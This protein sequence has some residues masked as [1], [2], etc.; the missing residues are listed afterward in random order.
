MKE[1]DVVVIGA[2]PAGLAAANKAAA[3][4]A[5]VLAIDSN[6]SP[7][8]QLV[9][10]I[11]KFFGSADICAGTRGIHLADKFYDEAKKNGC[12][13]MLGA[14]V[15]AIERDGKG[16]MIYTGDGRKTWRIR[17]KTTVLALG[18]SENAI[19][20]DGW[21]K[22][23][24]ITA[25]AAQTLVNQY[26][27]LC[28]KKVLMVGSGNVGLIVS[29]QLTQ[30][31]IDIAAIVEAAPS[32]G[33]YEVH[34]N[35]VRRAG[36]PIY[37]ST[38]IVSAEGEESVTGAVIADVDRNFQP[39]KGTERRLDVD[40]ICIS[41]GLSPLIKLAA[42]CGCALIRND[43]RETVP[44][45]DDCLMTSCPGIFAAGDMAGV[46]EASIALEE[47]AIVGN[48]VSVYLGIAKEED[49]KSEIDE[50]KARLAELRARG[51]KR[52]TRFNMALY[53]RYSG[54]KVVV[55]CGQ[56]I[57]CNPCEKY[58]PAHAI[59]VGKEITNNPEAHLDLCVGCGK[60][61]VACPGMACF[62][63]NMNYSEVKAEIGMPYEYLPVP[64]EGSIVRGLDRNGEYVCDAE[65]TRV[66]KLK[67]ADSTLLLK[68][69]VPKE[70]A[71]TVRAIDR[72]KVSA[73]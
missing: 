23:G 56:G 67:D 49:K 44:K 35:K 38:T 58:C 24:V 33:G 62:L 46:E 69:S 61:V 2:G 50:A 29:Y 21:T 3:N 10:Q 55:E 20:F 42:S 66:Q 43:K 53:E 19:A 68:I 47:G 7:G 73:E 4:G 37:T 32:I 54:S 16:Y 59:H 64:L 52:A 1:Y 65:V 18:A 30:A 5:S 48:A 15:Y 31:G 72:K 70:Y 34:A 13:F 36:I 63:I 39:I 57:P 12:Q 71:G 22:P 17:T 41:V 45:L 11:H 28:G 26:R 14:S 25:G 40:T 51:E 6:L 60:C 27:V 8:G 9:K